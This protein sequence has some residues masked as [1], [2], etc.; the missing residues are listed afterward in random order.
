MT[1]GF[2][3]AELGNWHEQWA[4]EYLQP[5]TLVTLQRGV[6]S[7]EV[8]AKESVAMSISLICHR[9]SKKK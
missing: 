3:H 9:H 2:S 1:E 6:N 5:L 7:R 8:V 4:E